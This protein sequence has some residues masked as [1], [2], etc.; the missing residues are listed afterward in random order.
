LVAFICTICDGLLILLGASGLGTV[1]AEH[2]LLQKVGSWG[3]AVFLFWFGLRSLRAALRSDGLV[4]DKVRFS[5]R[6][7]VVAATFAV[8][9]L[10][11]HVYLDTILLLGSISGQYD[12]D[13]RLLFAIGASASS[14]I[15]FY[16]P[17]I[18]LT[19]PTAPLS[20]RTLMP[21]G[22]VGDLVRMACTRP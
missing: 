17:R 4:L 18:S 10:N 1:V 9:L 13:G 7:A 20:S 3:G 22:W 12:G 8:T 14:L 2:Q 6:R 21:C 11:P 19:L 15:W 16:S 5:S